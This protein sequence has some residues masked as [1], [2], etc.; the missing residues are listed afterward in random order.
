MKNS[1]H[2]TLHVGYEEKYLEETVNT[3]LQIDNNINYKNLF[4]E[5]IPNLSGTRYAF[6]SMVHISNINTLKSIYN[7]YFHS[8]INMK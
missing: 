6:R 7:A 8:I 4:E 1:A 2:S 3:K 5:M